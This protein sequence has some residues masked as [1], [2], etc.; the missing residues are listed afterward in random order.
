MI[1]DLGASSDWSAIA[2]RLGNGRTAGGV[3]ARWQILRA[4]EPMRTKPRWK[5]DEDQRLS[6]LVRAE[7]ASGRARAGIWDR[8]AAEFPDRTAV[9]AD[10]RWRTLSR[11][12]ARDRDPELKRP[13]WTADEDERLS[14]LVRAAPER[15]SGSTRPGMWDR[16]ALSFPDRT[17]PAVEN[18]WKDRNKKAQRHATAAPAPPSKTLEKSQKIRCLQ[19]NPKQKGTACRD[20]YE[21]YKSATTV[22]EF[23][24]KEGTPAD[25]DHDIGRGF[26]EVIQ[27]TPAP[28]I[29]GDPDRKKRPREGPAAPRWSPD[30][31]ARLRQI[32]E[33]E[34]K[35]IAGGAPKAGVWDRVAVALGTNRTGGAVSQHWSAMNR[36]GTR[37]AAARW[38]PDDEQK[39]RRLVE[40]E[41][42]ANRGECR[43]SFWAGAAEALG[44]KRT[45][46]A[47][48]QHW[49]DMNSTRASKK[50]R[51]DEPPPPE[52]AD[53]PLLDPFGLR[54]GLAAL[55]SPWGWGS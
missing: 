22:K 46:T 4:D 6:E 32:V 52:E 41:R 40:A 23:Y 48:R 47:V 17:A 49:Q 9:E 51:T 5:A 44:T 34:R 26:I 33:A 12:D 3:E 31:E 21:K 20:R 27:P 50:A 15:A 25:L 38:T 36:D 16:I 39:L 55:F 2:A 8:I 45:D 18:H 30:E 24:E 29:A 19:D 37:T 53:D 14:E 13:R 7:R 42:A 43:G 28:L 11:R 1:G 54:A 10:N 35:A